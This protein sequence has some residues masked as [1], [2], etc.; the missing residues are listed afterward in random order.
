MQ[1]PHKAKTA[2]EHY[3]A[4]FIR[5][6]RIPA[7]SDPLVKA[8]VEENLRVTRFTGLTPQE[9][10]LAP[11]DLLPNHVG[12]RPAR[13]GTDEHWSDNRHAVPRGVPTTMP[14]EIVAHQAL[15]FL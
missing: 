4:D 13:P 15:R 7:T 14:L 11:G 8:H 3:A 10:G 5:R 9:A 2:E 12:R 1:V 6:Q